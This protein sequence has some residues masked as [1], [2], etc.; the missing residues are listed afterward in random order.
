MARPAWPIRP[1]P[2]QRPPRDVQPEA[3]PEPVV[4]GQQVQTGG[5]FKAQ[6]RGGADSLQVDILEHRSLSV[7]RSS[8]TAWRSSDEY[9]WGN[10]KAL[11]ECPNLTKVQL[12][13]LRQDRTYSRGSPELR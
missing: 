8:S 4:S 6:L 5:E 11:G 13:L 3:L 10:P 1:R 12:S 9:R 2:S 7:L